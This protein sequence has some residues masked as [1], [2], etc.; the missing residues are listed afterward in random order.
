MFRFP[1]ICFLNLLLFFV[2]HFADEIDEFQI[3]H[4]LQIEL[5]RTNLLIKNRFNEFFVENMNMFK[6]LIRL[7]MRDA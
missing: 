2:R 5:T 1:T 6:K 3:I 4:R 7:N